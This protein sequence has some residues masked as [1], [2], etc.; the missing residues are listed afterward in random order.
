MK[1]S[2]MKSNLTSAKR[3]ENTIVHADMASAM[4]QAFA[5]LPKQPLT[6]AR[7]SRLLGDYVYRDRE[8]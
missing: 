6:C 5:S 3:Q 4:R 1:Q 2:I 8:D 7:I